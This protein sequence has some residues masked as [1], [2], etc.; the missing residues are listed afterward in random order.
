ML[1]KR[2]LKEKHKKN[3]KLYF[4]TYPTIHS[5][6]R[7][8]NLQKDKRNVNIEKKIT[9]RSQPKPKGRNGVSIKKSKRNENNNKKR[10]KLSAYRLGEASRNLK[11]MM[12]V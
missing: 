2:F 12:L 1:I 10:K 8:R 4:K 11:E 5:Q 3:S 6:V 7:F 9:W